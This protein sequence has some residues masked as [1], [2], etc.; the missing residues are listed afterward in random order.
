VRTEG[1]DLLTNGGTYVEIGNISRERTVTIDPSA[2]LRGKKIMG[3]LMYRP[4]LLPLMMETLVKKRDTVPY[5]RIVSHTYPLA[6]VNRA[7]EES[8]WREPGDAGAIT[9]T[10][11]AGG[12]AARYEA[13]PIRLSNVMV[14]CAAV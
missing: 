10:L 8:E 14:V 11:E 13:I 2:L 6:D 3:S 12:R 7:F 5:D 4:Q 9:D 1:S